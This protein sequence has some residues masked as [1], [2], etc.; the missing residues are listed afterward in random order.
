M[1]VVPLFDVERM[2]LYNSWLFDQD[3]RIEASSESV[4]AEGNVSPASW[5]TVTGLG[6]VPCYIDP[7]SGERTGGASREITTPSGRVAIVSARI[8]LKGQYPTITE[9]MRVTVGG[10]TYGIVAPPTIAGMAT[11][12]LGEVRR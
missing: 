3:A 5:S 4:D 11:L 8:Y 6:A 7:A 9:E 1:E 2:L 12:L 10:T